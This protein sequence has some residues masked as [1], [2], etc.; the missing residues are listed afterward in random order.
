[1]R[2]I[3][4]LITAFVALAAPL[5]AQT[6]AKKT[7]SDKATQTV[8]DQKTAPAASD[9]KSSDNK[10]ASSTVPAQDNYVRPT[11]DKRFKKYV[12]SMFGP[13]SIGRAVASAGLSTWDN[14]P[15]EWGP[16][17][18]GFGKRFASNMGRSIM[19]NTMMYG[20]D[21]TFKLDS[22]YY[23][24]KKRDFKSK[25]VNAMI[26]PVVARQPDGKKVFGFPRVIST[27]ASSVIVA[28]TWY[29]GTDWKDGLRNG[30]MTLLFN[31]G[32][33]LLKEFIWKK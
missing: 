9:D 26:S 33:N 27:Y 17:W 10:T 6:D 19:K 30:S 5:S 20:M 29:P 11:A 1:M 32:Y 21:E 23:R 24:S 13:W 18:D 14:K 28:E 16:H 22:Y 15:E 7:D 8:T 2:T 4:L 12:G 31:G 25:V 3:A